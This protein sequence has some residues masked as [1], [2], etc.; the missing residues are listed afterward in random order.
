MDRIAYERAR[1]LRRKNRGRLRSPE[2]LAELSAAL[3]RPLGPADL[4]PLETGDRLRA[5]ALPLAR[6]SRQAARPPA[7]SAWPE[8]AAEP[9]NRGLARLGAGLGD[10]LVLYLPFE[11]DF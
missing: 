8:S 3:Q 4:H 1:F 7:F 5:V 11:W 2:I 9:L 6:A 10:A